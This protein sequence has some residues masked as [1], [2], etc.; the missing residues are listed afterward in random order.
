MT[1]WRLGAHR[2]QIK[3]ADKWRG[4]MLKAGRGAGKTRTG[5]QDAVEYCLDNPGARYAI[6][7]PTQ[8]DV[9]TVCF[10]GDSGVLSV[11]R[12]MGIEFHWRASKLEAEMGN[13]SIMFGYSAEKPDRLRGPQ[14]H[15]AWCDELAAW[16]DAPLGDA[17]GTTFN[18][19]SMGL[20]LGD[21]AR[22]IITTTPKRVALVREILARDDFVTT[23]GT[24]YDN[25][26]NLS[27]NFADALKRYEGTHIGRQ[28]LMGEM[29]DDVEGALWTI[30]MI[31]QD[32]IHNTAPAERIVVAIDPP[33]GATEAGI[34]AAGLTHRCVCGEPG[35]HAYVYADR[36]LKGSP[37]EWARTAVNLYHNLSADRI[38]AEI[39]YG[40]DMVEKVVRSVEP[41]IPYTA[42][43]ATR[44][45]L[46]RAE[47]IAALYEQHRVHHIGAFAD[48]ESEM[49]TW[50]PEEVWSPNRLDALVWALTELGLHE[51]GEL[52][53]NV[54]TVL[55]ARI[56]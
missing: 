10:E 1:D 28:E 47:P 48:L 29:I 39:N 51:S 4:W 42:V 6:I 14:F 24:T 54:K 20:R 35:V 56:G 32:R 36:S 16:K 22:M 3:P 5:A 37:D 44:G 50:T 13:G 41:N 9:R 11:M 33:G 34:V 52:T 23:N 8:G 40:G 19:L 27:P 25:I 17:L 45:K 55:D 15:R 30:E 53:S 7:A 18:N 49:T 43:R 31:D 26:A 46:I 21:D 38:V 2:F 12:D